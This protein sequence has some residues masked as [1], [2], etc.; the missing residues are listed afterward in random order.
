MMKE[1]V[2]QRFISAVNYLLDS[3]TESNKYTIAQK[4]GLKT[5]M[6]S[7]ILKK[8]VNVGIEHIIRL[9]KNWNIS[10]DWILDGSG[11]MIKLENNIKN[12]DFKELAESRKETAELLREKIKNLEEEISQL[13]KAK[14]N[15]SG[16]GMVAE[17]K[18][19]LKSK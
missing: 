16:Y 3:N 17:S 13:K 6:F 1:A 19:K 11:E 5:S 2:N 14:E 8:R 18:Q 10:Y 9:K 12:L 4:L 15:P 7:E